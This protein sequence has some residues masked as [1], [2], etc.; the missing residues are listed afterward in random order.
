MKNTKTILIGAV[1]LVCVTLAIT[2]AIAQDESIEAEK[3]RLC[4][5]YGQ[6]D[7]VSPDN[8]GA[9][10]QE[11][12]KSMDPVSEPNQEMMAPARPDIPDVNPDSLD[13]LMQREGHFPPSE[14]MMPPSEEPKQ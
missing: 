5:Q 2:P 14:E 9:Y 8:M 3:L 1:S 11:C 7:Q 10:I 13:S 4:T 6:E 12:L